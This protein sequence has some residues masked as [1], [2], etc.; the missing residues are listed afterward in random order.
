MLI[1]PGIFYLMPKILPTLFLRPDFVVGI[2]VAFA[3]FRLAEVMPRAL[4]A[5][6]DT[7]GIPFFFAISS[8][9]FRCLLSLI[10][11]GYS[12]QFIFIGIYII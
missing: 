3:I 7:P 5:L 9:S 8:T 12:N 2:P 4:L 11:F 10:Y 6:N 1:A